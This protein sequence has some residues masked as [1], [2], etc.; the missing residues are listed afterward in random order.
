MDTVRSSRFFTAAPAS[1]V[2]EAETAM[3]PRFGGHAGVCLLQRQRRS[4]AA[5]DELVD[6]FKDLEPKTTLGEGLRTK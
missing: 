5:M 3:T 2:E 4:T 6:V 1:M